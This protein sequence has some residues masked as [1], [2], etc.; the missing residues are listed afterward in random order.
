MKTNT[1]RMQ[2]VSI[3]VLTICRKL[4]KEPREMPRTGNQ[5]ASAF[6]SGKCGDCFSLL[7]GLLVR[8]QRDCACT[9]GGREGRAL[10]CSPG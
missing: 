9:Q 7:C 8:S 1:E 6:S 4:G 2:P 3:Q 5:K 10:V